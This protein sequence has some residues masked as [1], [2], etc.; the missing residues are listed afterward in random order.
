MSH[1]ALSPTVLARALDIAKAAAAMA[2]NLIDECIDRRVALEI[3]Q[4]SSSADMVTQY[5]KQC[6]ELVLKHLSTEF[7]DFAVLSEETKSDVVITDAPTWIVDP[8]DG[9]TSFVHNSFDC[10][11]SIGLAVNKR[12]V[13]GVVHL[14]R[15]K[16]VFTAIE[17]QGAFLNGRKIS[18]SSITDPAKAI[19]CTHVPYNRSSA[20]VAALLGINRELMQDLKVHA[21]RTYGSAA[22]DMC[23]VACGRLDLYFEVGIHAWDMAAAAVIVREAGGVVHNV[24]DPSD[25][26]NLDLSSRGMSCG[27]NHE[28]SKLG[29]MLATKHNYRAAVLDLPV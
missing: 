11:V 14:P 6:E 10:G 7:P 28:M 29:T 16:E 23:S 21:V 26:M 4:K 25:K 9:T 5:D 2:A 8:I 18:V 13:L 24:D 22:M 27:S 1:P 15:M 3:E 20:S 19:V 12:P 17:G